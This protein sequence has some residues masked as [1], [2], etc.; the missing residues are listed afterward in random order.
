MHLADGVLNLPTIA[1]TGG[2]AIG[3]LAYGCYKINE[4]EIPRISLLTGT[5]FAVSLISI[6]IGPSSVHPILCGLIGI[7]LGKRAP[8]VFFAGLLLQAIIFQHGGLTTLGANV[9]M[10]TVPAWI[11]SCIFQRFKAV[12]IFVRGAT[13]GAVSVGGALM[14][15]IFILS[16]SSSMFAQGKFSV[17]NLLILAHIPLVI[18]EAA[19]TGFAVN[20]IYRSKPQWLNTK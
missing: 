19:V 2:A 13:A 8:I 1:V 11:S 6:P 3:A 9:I 20:L 17:I 4:E 14:M 16:L 10:L 12:S 15:L 5:F 18:I 7:L